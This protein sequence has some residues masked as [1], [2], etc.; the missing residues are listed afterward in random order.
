MAGKQQLRKRAPPAVRFFM[1]FTQSAIEM[2]DSKSHVDW[3]KDTRSFVINVR[4]RLGSLYFRC[5]SV[6]ITSGELS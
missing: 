5:Q 1:L 2:A 4:S 6:N 3:A